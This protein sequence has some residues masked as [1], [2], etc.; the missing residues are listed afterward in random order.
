MNVI[1]HNT[2]INPHNY[3]MLVLAGGPIMNIPT[4]LLNHIKNINKFKKINKSFLIEGV[5]YGPLNTKLSKF[6]SNKI[7]MK[8]DTISLR[9]KE[10]FEKVIKFRKDSI[11]TYDPAFDYLKYHLKRLKESKDKFLNKILKDEKKICV[12]NLRP[13]D[14]TYTTKQGVEDSEN[15]M[16]N[17]LVNFI[18]KESKTFKFVFMPMN[19]DQFGFCD[20]EIAYKLEKKIREKKIDA[21][22]KIW[23]T[24][25]TI[26]DCLLLLNKA[27]LTISMRFH[28]CIFSLS[29]NTPTIGI[30]YSTVEKGKVYNLFKNIQKENQVVSLTS[31][32]KDS[33]INIAKK[34]I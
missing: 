12:I 19:S 17:S 33:V 11:E 14:K 31:F 25:T 34:L 9:T 24:E 23:E 5:G 1:A 6:L 20:L 26:N 2:N 10:D 30:D 8:S 21:E 7:I 27:S 13:S 32:K 3:D 15:K 28:G 29:T 22:Y 16:I 4:I 18:D